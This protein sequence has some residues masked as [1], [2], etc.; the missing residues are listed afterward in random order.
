MRKLLILTTLFVVAAGA[1]EAKTAVAVCKDGQNLQFNQ[2]VGGTG[3]L[4]LKTPAGIY[5]IAHFDSA[6][7]GGLLEICGAEP[8]QGGAAAPIQLCI[9]AKSLIFIREQKGA[10]V[11]DTPVCDANV[12]LH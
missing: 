2:T 1:A 6:T 10:Q 11:I 3:L 12:K 5:Q 7:Q 4:Y 8:G 9:N